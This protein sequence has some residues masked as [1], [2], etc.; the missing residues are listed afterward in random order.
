MAIHH[1]HKHPIH[2]Q[3]DRRYHRCLAPS[4]HA[5]IKQRWATDSALAGLGVDEILDI[6]ATPT[7]RQNP[8]IQALIR[9]H[10]ADDADATTVLL[11]AL[12]PSLIRIEATLSP[13]QRRDD[14]YSALWA[15]AGHLLATID[16]EH[17]PVSENGCHRPLISDL[18][19]RLRTS[20]RVLEPEVRNE[21]RRYQRDTQPVIVSIDTSRIQIAVRDFEPQVFAAMELERVA[22]AVSS[23][24]L[25]RHRW[26]QLVEHRLGNQAGSNAVRVGAHRAAAQLAELVGHEAA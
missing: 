10:Q 12:L 23:G 15:A 5:R 13:R 25:P 24:Q 9:R 17:E 3:L 22:H 20:R 18:A 19:T 4:R 7:A 6:C 8:I 16:P 1:P 14:A 11:I 2:Q 21:C 26:L